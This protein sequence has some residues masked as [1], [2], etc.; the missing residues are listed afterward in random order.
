MF[1]IEKVLKNFKLRP[2]DIFLPLKLIVR[3]AHQFEFEMPALVCSA[4]YQ[5][6]FYSLNLFVD[7]NWFGGTNSE[8]NCLNRTRFRISEIVTLPRIVTRQFKE[9]V[10]V[11]RDFE[12]HAAEHRST[13]VSLIII[14]LKSQNL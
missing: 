3:P 5:F 8:R 13:S 9:F 7:G 1:E 11:S 14:Q 6:F 12:I 2:V 10:N 4:T